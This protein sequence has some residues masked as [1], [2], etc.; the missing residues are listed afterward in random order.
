MS[1]KKGSVSNAVELELSNEVTESTSYEHHNDYEYDIHCFPMSQQTEFDE[2]NL[3]AVITRDM[4]GNDIDIRTMGDNRY[5][6]PAVVNLAFEKE[7]EEQVKIC[8]DLTMETD[9]NVD[10]LSRKRR[11]S[12]E[13]SSE[14]IVAVTK[15][16]NV[17]IDLSGDCFEV[18]DVD[19]MLDKFYIVPEKTFDNKR[20]V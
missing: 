14:L 15:R 12:S 9:L 18:E 10:K 4:F 8:I 2:Y 6:T 17:C 7:Q 11:R 13:D 5:A 19:S 20:L 16:P 3:E 1:K